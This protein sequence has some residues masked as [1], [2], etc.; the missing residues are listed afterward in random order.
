MRTT[1]GKTAPNV[2]TVPRGMKTEDIAP[3]MQAL[4]RGDSWKLYSACPPDDCQLVSDDKI[5]QHVAKMSGISPNVI[6]RQTRGKRL[7]QDG[8]MVKALAKMLPAENTTEKMT[9]WNRLRKLGLKAYGERDPT[10]DKD[11]WGV[12]L[13][14]MKQRNLS[15]F[16]RKRLLSMSVLGPKETECLIETLQGLK[17]SIEWNNAR[18][19]FELREMEPVSTLRMRRQPY[20]GHPDSNTQRIPIPSGRPSRSRGTRFEFSRRSGGHRRADEVG[21]NREEKVSLICNIVLY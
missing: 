18:L 2:S 13:E 6:A 5:N 19:D 4:S 15:K 20:H 12:A 10:K 9:K 16:D 14:R 17:E 1:H 21:Q 8:G 11:H 7:S 3:T